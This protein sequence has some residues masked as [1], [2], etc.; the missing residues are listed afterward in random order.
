MIITA[1]STMLAALTQAASPEIVQDTATATMDAALADL[2]AD[3]TPELIRAVEGGANQVLEQTAE[4]WRPSQRWTFTQDDS[5]SEDIAVADF[6]RDGWLDV[7]FANED[8]R[9]QQLY[10]G[11]PDGFVDVSGRLAFY[12]RANAVEAGDFDGDGD[13]DL[14][15]GD[16][17]P[18]VFLVNDGSGRF[19]VRRE[20]DPAGLDTTQDLDFADVDGDGDLDLFVANEEA[21]RLLLNDGAG[22]FTDASTQMSGSPETDETREGVFADI[23]GDGDLDLFLANVGFRLASAAADSGVQVRGARDRLLINDGTGRFADEAEARLPE[24]EAHTLDAKFFDAD[25]DGDLNMVI[26]AAFGGGVRLYLND[27]AGRFSLARVLVAPGV[28][29]L[30]IE[31]LPGGRGVYVASFRSEDRVANVASSG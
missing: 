31:I 28:D 22:R 7:A 12:A 14:V 21:N 6:N 26:G 8:T 25:A 27:G 24:W 2:D 17:G 9:V 3:G 30:D 16:E 1:L 13:E 4:G 23:D 29:V 5:D 18:L 10:F 20:P 11:G 19:D 15:F